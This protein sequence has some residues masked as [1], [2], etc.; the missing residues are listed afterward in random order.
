MTLLHSRARLM[1]IYSQGL[2]DEVVRRCG[3]LGV[4]VVL[5]ERVME[6]PAA[7]GTLDGELKTVKTDKGSTL[8]AELV[9]VC[10]GTKPHSGFMRALDE[11]TI[12][13]NNCIRVK[14]TMQVASDDGRWDHF[15][16]IGDCADTTAI[17]A[18]HMSFAQGSVASR[19]IVR[20]IL[21]KEEEKAAE[22]EN[23]V[24][25]EAKIKVTLGLKDFCVATPDEAVPGDNGVPD[26]N[27]KGMWMLA[28]AQ[29]MPDDA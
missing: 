25:D 6:W 8:S 16:A 24:P 17:R 7:P 2:H 20:L 22:L 29:G 4:N 10:T 13:A 3:A 27:A 5:G 9:L 21:A 28:G 18:G 23:Y 14:D 26:I 1:P 19:N 15:F 12:A 11:S